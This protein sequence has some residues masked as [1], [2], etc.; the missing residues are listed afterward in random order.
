ELAPP[1]PA[2]P[3]AGN[4]DD[5]PTIPGLLLKTRVTYD[6]KIDSDPIFEISDFSY[7]PPADA[8]Y[9]TNP[10]DAKK[11][12]PMTLAHRIAELNRAAAKREKRASPPPKTIK[13]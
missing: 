1:E 13:L 5:L 2:D 9:L 7:A 12:P 11:K 10:I 3:N 6:N 8:F 4:P